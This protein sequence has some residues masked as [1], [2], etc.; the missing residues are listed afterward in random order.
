M[1]DAIGR[2]QNGQP[3][4][5]YTWTPNWTVGTLKPGEDV[6]WL[7]LRETML[8]EDQRDLADETTVDDLA[9]CR[10]PQPCNLGWP[11]NDIRPVANSDF[12]GDNPAVAA[13]LR[14][15][16][17]PIEDIFVQNAKM[18][19]GEDSPEDL[20]RQAAAWIDAHR[21]QVDRWLKTAR[22]AA[23]AM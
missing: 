6:V 23:Q 21:G 16:R 20:Q 7:Q 2:Y 12:L 11:V 8:P 13:L 10:G 18:N 17:I 3:I 5:F 19:A 9:G 4:F 1:A 14:N 15:V 22:E